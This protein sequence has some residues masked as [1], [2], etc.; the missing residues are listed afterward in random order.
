MRLDVDNM[1]Y[2]ELLALEER[3]GSVNTG[4]TDETVSKCLTI[5][6]YLASTEVEST[7]ENTQKCSICQEEYEINDEIGTL[8]CGHEH[9]TQCIMKWLL[10]KNECPIC[11][12]PA[13]KNN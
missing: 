8:K 4:L 7:D 9:H 6:R 10:Q 12:A 3:I 2:E 5:K 11:K 13:S 1:T